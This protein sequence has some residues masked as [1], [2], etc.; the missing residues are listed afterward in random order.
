MQIGKLYEL[1]QEVVFFYNPTEDIHYY[2]DIGDIFL[3]IKK[4]KKEHGNQYHLLG[5]DGKIWIRWTW[6][7]YKISELLKEIKN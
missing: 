5:P 2:W 6:M 1:T 3:L 7:N 4:E